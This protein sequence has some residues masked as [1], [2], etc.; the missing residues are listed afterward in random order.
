MTSVYYP[1]FPALYNLCLVRKSLFMSNLGHYARN[2]Q[3][4]YI[5][6]DYFLVIFLYPHCKLDLGL[7]GMD[8]PNTGVMRRLY[9]AAFSLFLSKI[10]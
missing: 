1:D 9:I 3:Y 2:K 8:I 4:G 7:F 5:F 10:N 6:G